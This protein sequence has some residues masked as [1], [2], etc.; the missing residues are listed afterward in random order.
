MVERA[1]RGAPSCRSACVTVARSIHPDPVDESP[2]VVRADEQP[3]RACDARE[4]AGRRARARAAPDVAGEVLA[5][6]TWM[7]GRGHEIGGR[8]GLEVPGGNAKV[9]PPRFPRRDAC[10]LGVIARRRRVAVGQRWIVNIGTRLPGR[11]VYVGRAAL[12]TPAC[13][14]WDRQKT[15]WISSSVCFGFFGSA[16]TS[17]SVTPAP[18]EDQRPLTVSTSPAVLAGVAEVRAS[19]EDWLSL[20]GAGSAGARWPRR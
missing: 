20:L 14:T 9:A 15:R 8:G 2:R 10:R 11:R 12:S 19:T 6:R 17:A 18:S 3:F 16:Q 4:R 5:S 13:A 7:R 1:L